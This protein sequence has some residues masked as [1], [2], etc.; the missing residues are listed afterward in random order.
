MACHLVTRE[1]TNWSLYCEVGCECVNFK[2]VHLGVILSTRIIL[3][4]NQKRNRSQK[5]LLKATCIVRLYWMLTVKKPK[6]NLVMGL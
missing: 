1:G 4:G 3:L 2:A 6:Q 5:Q